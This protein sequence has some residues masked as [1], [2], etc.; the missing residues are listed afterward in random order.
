MNNTNPPI[1]VGLS[2]GV[3]SAV[4]ALLLKQQGYPIQALFMK[5]WEEDDDSEYCSAAE[6]LAD[7]RAVCEQLDMPLHTVNFSGEYWENVFTHCLAE[8]KAGRTP[9]PD[10]LCNRDIKF[11]VF[12]EH[13]QSLGA[14]GI[15][16]GHY[17]R[18]RKTDDG[19]QLLKAIDENKDQSYFLY[20]L[21]QQQLA[22]SQFPLG[23]LQKDQVRILAKQAGLV[24]HAKKDSTGIC[25]IGERPFKDFLGQYLPAQPGDIITLDGK[26]IGRHDGLM[27]H[28]VGQRK[29]LNIGGLASGSGEAWYVIDKHL[30]HN[31]L[32]VAQGHQHP[33]LFKSGLIATALHWISGQAPSLPFQAQAKIRYRQTVQN[34]EINTIQNGQCHVHFEQH[35]RAV[36]SGQSIVFYDEEVCL[37]GGIIV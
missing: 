37:G 12:L 13:A 35:Q 31:Q 27:Y 30:D 1:M 25:F 8:F 3:D 19:Y 7:A 16:T 22:H 18:I 36:T 2:G 11:K 32:L 20:L 23:E 24:N 33:R 15:A 26:K 10:V 14:S 6:D 17:A 4:T 29:G 28:T 9:N 21:N 5:N 34:C